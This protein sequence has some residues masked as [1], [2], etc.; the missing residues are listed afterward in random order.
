MN[1]TIGPLGFPMEDTAAKAVEEI[2]KSLPKTEEFQYRKSLTQGELETND[3][4][5]TDVSWITTEA[6]DA[7]GHIV[8][9]SGMNDTAYRLNPIVTLNHAYDKPPV[10]RSLW[11]KP[12]M[13][14]GKTGIRARTKYPPRPANYSG[15]WEPEA[16]FALVQAGLLNG[17]SI[18]LLPTEVHYADRLESARRNCPE[19]TLVIDKWTLLEYACCYL[20]I[21]SEALVEEIQKSGIPH[22][23]E[24][25]LINLIAKKISS[26]NFSDLVS[27]ALE[28]AAGKV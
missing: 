3:L 22:T 10:G 8:I 5:R 26:Y 23:T 20:P 2:L 9:A 17:K 12:Y 18:G 11:R 15:E 14:N 27:T 13:A 7:Q 21:Q 4:A 19:G 6:L 28:R 24:Q 25:E 16:A 1:T